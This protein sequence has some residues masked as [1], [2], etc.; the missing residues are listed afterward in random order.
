MKISDRM[1]HEDRDTTE[2]SANIDG[3]RL[4]Y[5]VPRS[6]A[7]TDSGDPFLAAALLPA[8]R[9]GQKIEIDPDLSVSPQLLEN[10]Q[11]LQEIHHTWNPIFKIVPIEARTSP[12]RPLHSGVMSFFSGG[13]DSLYTFLKRQARADASRLHP[14]LRFFRGE[15]GRFRAIDRGGPDRSVTA[16]LQA[17]DGRGTRSPP[18]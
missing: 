4:W 1:I 2:I 14:G 16:R 7:V 12:S 3:F 17:H 18:F 9:L 5:R 15:R 8:M 10:L 11:T 6:Y 13:V